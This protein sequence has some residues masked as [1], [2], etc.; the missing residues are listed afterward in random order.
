M[1]GSGLGECCSLVW[2]DRHRENRSVVG[3]VMDWGGGL[4]GAGVEAEQPEKVVKRQAVMSDKYFS[5]SIGWKKKGVNRGEE[6]YISSSMEG[7]FLEEE[8]YREEVSMGFKCVAH[9]GR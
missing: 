9:S 1:A 6:G 2:R 7:Y 4:D 3:V 8:V 5:C